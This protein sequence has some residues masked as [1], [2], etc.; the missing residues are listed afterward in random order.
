M[1]GTYR[2]FMNILGQEP[3]LDSLETSYANS[4][5]EMRDMIDEYFCCAA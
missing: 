4:K 5:E 2:E 1:S 3:H